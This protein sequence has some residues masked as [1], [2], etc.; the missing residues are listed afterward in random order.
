MNISKIAPKVSVCVVTYNQENYIR[1]CLQSVVDQERHFEIEVIVSDDCSTDNTPN[2]VREFAE[3]YDFII[4]V[5]R[6]KNIGAFKNFVETHNIATGEYVCHLDG[7]DYW[8]PG[9]I[10]SQVNILEGNHQLSV[11]W[12]RVDIFTDTGGFYSGY[13]TDYSMFTNGIITLHHALKLGSIGAHSSIMYKRSA[14]KTINPKIDTLDFFYAWEYLSSGDGIIIDKVLGKYRLDSTTSIRKTENKKILYPQYAMIF[15]TDTERRK[16]LFIFSIKGLLYSIK[17]FRY[18]V[19]LLYLK[20][21][22]ANLSIIN[23]TDI[24]KS[25][26]E[27]KKLSKWPNI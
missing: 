17:N 6:E 24:I 16:S 1:Q 11:A 13:N 2:I 12:H 8:L 22:I 26:K 4:P 14:R 3:K 9:K 10:K 20:A 27:D 7:D 21:I 19:S 15:N 5:L 18:A 25:I 23:I